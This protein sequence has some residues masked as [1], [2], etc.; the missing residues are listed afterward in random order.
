[1]SSKTFVAFASFTVVI[2]AAS[3]RGRSSLA[4]RRR[5]GYPAPRR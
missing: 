1:M 3:L 2:A 5:S 4:M